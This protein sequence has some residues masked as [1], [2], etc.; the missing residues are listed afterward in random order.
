MTNLHRKKNEAKAALL[1]EKEFSRLVCERYP[2]VA[3]IVI[4]MRYRSEGSVAL[5]RTLH[6]YPESP[7]FFK[8]NCLGQ[9]CENGGLNLTRVINSMIRNHDRS[10]KGS[11]RCTN[12]VPDVV[13]AD[14]SYD[15]SV[16]YVPE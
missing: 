3:S 6:F 9:G 1:K 16:K 11:L 7:A 2:D 13:H 5:K 15:I 4:R 12:R 14:M 8:M 10:I